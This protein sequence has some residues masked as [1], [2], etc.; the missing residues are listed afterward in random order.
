MRWC[1]NRWHGGT[2]GRH[3]LSQPF[4]L[5]APSE[6]EPGVGL[7][8]STGCSLKSGVGGRFSSPLR[9]SE[10]FYRLRSPKYTPSVSHSLD[11]SLREGAGMGLYHSTGYSLKS[12]GAG[13]TMNGIRPD[14]GVPGSLSEGAAERSEAE[15]VSS[16]GC[17]GPMVYPPAIINSEIFYR[18]RSSGYTPSVSHSL[19]SSLREG[20]GGGLAPFNRV[21]AKPRGYGRF[22]SP[23]R[24]SEIFTGYEQRSI[25]KTGRFVK[26]RPARGGGLGGGLG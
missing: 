26:N 18:L 8:H 2:I 6:R 22:S 20:A 9:N 7:H 21:L 11:S 13:G 5:P 25:F 1:V 15:G 16:D 14:D 12:G 3:S 4:G 10:Y 24:N 17:S 19:D 23:L